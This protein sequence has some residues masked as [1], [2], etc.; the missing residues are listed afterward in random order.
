MHGREIEL[1][2]LLNVL[3]A[4]AHPGESGPGRRDGLDALVLIEGEPG[5][6]KSRLLAEFSQHASAEGVLVLSGKADRFE[7][8]VPYLGWRGVLARLLGL[9]SGM[10]R[11]GLI[12]RISLTADV[13]W[14]LGYRL[15]HPRQH[16]G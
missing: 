14:E 16:F 11:P 10:P 8:G 3:H 15:D 12:G 1:A 5:I 6:G 7:S 13:A 9:L 4:T 2:A